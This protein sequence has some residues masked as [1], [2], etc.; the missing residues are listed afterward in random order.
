MK[1]DYLWDKKGNDS[2]IEWLENSLR[3]FSYK[4]ADA[5][6]IPASILQFKKEKPRTMIPYVHAL[7]AGFAF[8]LILTGIAFVYFNSITETANQRGDLEFVK[9]EIQP[10]QIASDSILPRKVESKSV[11]TLEQLKDAEKSKIRNKK[12]KSEKLIYKPKAKPLKVKTV[13]IVKLTEEEKE[14][15]EKLMLALSITSS[16]LKIVKDKVQNLEEQTAI[17]TEN[18]IDTRKK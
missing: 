5:P 10:E 7:A 16:K 18:S 8:A 11:S 2:E 9:N 15:Y 12:F 14:A 3:A 17:N 4:E 6:E 13:Y 1:D